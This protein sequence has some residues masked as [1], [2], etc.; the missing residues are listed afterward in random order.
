MRDRL[1]VHKKDAGSASRTPNSI[2]MLCYKS[3]AASIPPFHRSTVSPFHRFTVFCP[4]NKR[5]G[6][7]QAFW[8]MS[9]FY[10]NY[11]IMIILRVLLYLP[12][13]IL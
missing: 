13:L 4:I 10:Q 12:A 9:S 11:F 6:G 1:W 8:F 2:G 3:G 5:P 7:C